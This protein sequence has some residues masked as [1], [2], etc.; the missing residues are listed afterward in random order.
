MELWA[1]AGEGYVSVTRASR[2]TSLTFES[3]H[4]PK[5][6]SPKQPFVNARVCDQFGRGPSVSMI[7]QSATVP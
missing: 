3:L 6:P 4:T 7:L 1:A 5:K 2:L